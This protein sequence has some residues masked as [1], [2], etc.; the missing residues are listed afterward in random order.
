MIEDFFKAH[1]HTIAAIAAAGTLAAVVTSL[2]LAWSA[3]RADRTRLRASADIVLIFQS[4]IDGKSVP[5]FLKVS[6]TNI[7]KFPL[8]IQSGFFHWKV[9]FKNE[10]MQVPPLDLIGSPL[11]PSRHYPSVISPRA[12]ANFTIWDVDTFKQEVKRMRGLDTFADRL[13]FR[14]IRAFVR[15]DDGKTFR[16]K[17][18]PQVRAIWL[19]A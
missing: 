2:A 16:V 4:P 11:I 19:D 15:T 9:P 8:Q 12:S 6:I 7:G 13:R 1:Q 5:K 17:L 18:S 10:V 14:F 3:R